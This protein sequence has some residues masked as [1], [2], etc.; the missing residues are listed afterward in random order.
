MPKNGSAASN[1]LFKQPTYSIRYP[2]IR[3]KFQTGM[4]GSTNSIELA[5]KGLE[6]GDGISGFSI[7]A[8]QPV[9]SESK[10]V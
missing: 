7:R 10:S 6:D 9:Y 4:L 2:N 1:G 8:V 3:E 5:D